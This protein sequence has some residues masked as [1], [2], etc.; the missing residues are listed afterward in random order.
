ML[1]TIFNIFYVLVALA[2]C[3]LILLQ[4]GDGA[5]AGLGMFF[6]ERMAA[7]THFGAQQRLG[8]LGGSSD[9]ASP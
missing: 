4:R 1:L 8:A 3:V 5:A 7:R 6:G 9:H 2:M